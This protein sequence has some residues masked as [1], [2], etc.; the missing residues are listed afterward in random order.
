MISLGPRASLADTPQ[1]SAVE[2]NP[3]DRG[4]QDKLTR[5]KQEVFVIDQTLRQQRRI[6]DSSQL[7]DYSAH[8]SIPL[9]THKMSFNS[10][11]RSNIHRTSPRTI[12]PVNEHG[13][14]RSRSYKRDAYYDEY[15]D[16]DNFLQPIVI[17]NIGPPRAPGSQLDPTDP[18]GVKDILVGD[19]L[20]LIDRKMREFQEMNE[21]AS[22]LETWVCLAW[23][24]LLHAF[25][26][27]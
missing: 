2:A 11:E 25:W 8:R 15:D 24:S 9:E 5:F 17:E 19:S 22:E 23:S 26:V 20:A 14:S 10:R 3:L 21:R 27:Q 4:H 13:Y 18:S 1:E 16:D 12:Q 7:T 6:V